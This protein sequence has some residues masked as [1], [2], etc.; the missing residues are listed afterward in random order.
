MTRSSTPPELAGLDLANFWLDS[1]YARKEYIE[2]P[3][4]PELI[5]AIEAELVY[6]LP[7]SY[8]ALMHTQNGDIPTNTCFPTTTAT[9]WAED[10]VAITAFKGIGR[11]KTWSLC[12]GL[13]SAFKIDEWEYPAIGVYFGDCPSAG[14]D[15][16]A[17]DY[18]ACGPQGEPQVVHVDQEDDYHITVLAPD[19]PSFLRGLVHS[20]VYDEEPATLLQDTLEHVRHAP[21]GKRL[22]SLCDAW[23]DPQIDAVIR[24]LAEAITV[25]K[26]YFALHSDARSHLLY[27]LQFLLH[28]HNRPVKSLQGY[29]Q[30]Y[31]GVIACIGS[32]YF[33]TGGWAPSFVSD[34]FQAR[35]DSGRLVFDD[36]S[37]HLSETYREEVVQSLR[38][39]RPAPSSA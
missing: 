18:R 7:A 9:S 32:D 11:S 28:S 1:D 35:C 10:H 21:F 39:Y 4:T 16:I 31:P 30:S 8:V 14:H 34:W 37:W 15:M 23:P 5:A 17:L 19:F 12:G 33:G 29:L 25:D 2:P 24:A 3:P 26:G 27:D 38:A 13:G 36:G 6:T 22:Q 20:S